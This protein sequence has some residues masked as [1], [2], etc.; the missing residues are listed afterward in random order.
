MN[1]IG[2]RIQKH[3]LKSGLTQEAL[4]E[5]LGVS[6]QSVSK[7]EL[8]Q[9][10]PEVDKIIA[11][12]RLFSLT[13]DAILLETISSREQQMEDKDL[14]KLS[15]IY[16]I[17]KDMPRSIRFYEALLSMSVSTR[18]PRFAEFFF[19]HQCIALMDEKGLLSH[20]RGQQSQ[21]GHKFVLNFAIRDLVA[22]HMRLKS[23][24]LGP[25]TDIK[26]GTPSYYYFQIHDPDH[27]VIE[28]TGQVYD[29][30]RSEAMETIYC[31]SCA[32]PMKETQYGTL[33]DGAKTQEYCHYCFKDGH[34]TSNQTLEEAI[35][36]NIQFWLKDCNN[37]PDQARQRIREVFVT[38]NRWK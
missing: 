26:Q 20:E 11:I 6:R 25:M 15:S 27:N 34:F 32:M 33:A 1:T 29:T 5:R 28:I 16:L 23:L 8:D 22:E 38:L 36:S 19:H 18:H 2:Y 12:S 4:A 10:L 13:T 14:L 24:N 21:G 30:R 35:E 9:T 3:R 37:D 17:S 31:H 7:W